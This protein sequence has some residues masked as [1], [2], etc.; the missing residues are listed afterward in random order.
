MLDAIDDRYPPAQNT[1]TGLPLSISSR[2]FSNEGRLMCRALVMLPIS[3]SPGFRISINCILGTV[4]RRSLKA[5]TDSRDCCS[6]RSGFSTNTRIGSRSAPTTLSKPIR[7]RRI[8][9]SCSEPSS[10]TNT[11]GVPG[12]ITSPTYSA[13]LPERPTLIEPRR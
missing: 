11:M 2:R 8:L 4:A 12:S 3:T 5:S 1:T 13:N 7:A 6:T 10:H 9:A